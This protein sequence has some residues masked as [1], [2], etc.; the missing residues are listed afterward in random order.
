[1]MRRNAVLVVTS[2][3]VLSFVPGCS[4]FKK[5]KAAKQAI[6]TP[7]TNAGPIDYSYDPNYSYNANTAAAGPA[8]SSSGYGAT[9]ALASAAPMS[10]GGRTHTVQKGDTIFKLARDYYGGDASKWRA[11]YDANRDQISNPNQI[12]VGQRLVIP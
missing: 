8:Y 9:G 12:R 10:G 11:I 2:L 6:D 5:R 7:A 1:M 3:L 4:W